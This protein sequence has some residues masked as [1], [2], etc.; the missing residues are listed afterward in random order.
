MTADHGAHP[1]VHSLADR[2]EIAPG[3]LMPRLG[4]GTYKSE[5]GAQVAESVEAA[6]ELG[7]RGFDT[8][9]LYANEADVGRVLAES[10]IARE[11]LFVATKVWNSEQGYASTL[12]AFEGSIELLGMEYVDLYLVHWPIPSLMEPT[13]RAMEH[14]ARSG[15]ARAIGVCNHLPHHLEALLA[16]AEIPPAVDQ[17]ELHVWNQMR[18]LRDYAGERGITVQAWA[19]IIRGRVAEIP[20][21]ARIGA[22]HGKTPAQ[23]AIRWI[24]QSGVTT[25]P[26]SVHRARIAENADV[27]DFALSAEEMATVDAL[28]R[29]ERIGPDPDRY[30]TA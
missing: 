6:L 23:V 25:I 30:A 28:D 21:L 15:R 19:P 27:F 17:L 4:L 3:V 20:E 14:I 11:E 24:L 1:Q 5:P 9:A 29:E 13:W 22:R 16:L 8:A 18:D 2:V 12:A 10:G 26:K 7:Y